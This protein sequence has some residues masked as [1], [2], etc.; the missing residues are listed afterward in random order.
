MKSAFHLRLT[1]SEPRLVVNRSVNRGRSLWPD[2]GRAPL[3]FHQGLP[4]YAVTP[5]F[6]AQTL[7]AELGVGRVLIK[8]ENSR[9]GLPAFKILG[10][11]W[12]A[13]RAIEERLGESLEP[14]ASLEG[15]ASKAGG[16][17]R[18]RLAAATD[19]NYGC[20]VA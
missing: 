14:S 12:A 20:A 7:S 6:D 15:L 1:V 13:F 18:I 10:A 11:S 8:H 19:G 2:P 4:G 5:I 9:Y 17:G 3:A 16:L